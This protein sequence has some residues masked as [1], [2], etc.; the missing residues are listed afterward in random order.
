M[1]SLRT[2]YTTLVD[3]DSMFPVCQTQSPFVPL[4]GHVLLDSIYR[5]NIVKAI[6]HFIP[7]T[8][9]ACKFIFLCFNMQEVQRIKLEHPD[10]DHCIVNDR[11]KGRLKVTR[12]FGAGYLK[13]VTTILLSWL[14]LTPLTLFR[15]SKFVQFQLLAVLFWV[16]NLSVSTNLLPTV[17]AF[18]FF[19]IVQN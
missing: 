13:Q 9:H 1:H 12:A 15:S 10:D 3:L 4:F 8:I 11:V 16:M 17:I 18:I 5:L 7:C 6:G 2:P 14:L 19:I